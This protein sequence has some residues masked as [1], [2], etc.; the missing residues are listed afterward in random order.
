MNYRV[1]SL[2]SAFLMQ[3]LV[4][5]AQES[6]LGDCNAS[7]DVTLGEVMVCANIFLERQ[8]LANC[9][10]ADANG[11]GRVRISEVVGSAR[12][13][14]FGCPT[15]PP[16]ATPTPTATAT[17]TPT[18]TATP[19]PATATPTV[20]PTAT[21]TPTQ[22]L[23]CGNGLLEEAETCTSCPSDCEIAECTPSA[24]T[25]TFAAYL[26]AGRDV[27]AV[28]LDLNY[29]SDQ[30]QI[31]GSANNATVRARIT[32]LPTGGQSIINDRDYGVRIV[33]S[34]T[35]PLPQGELFQV[36]FDV[37]AGAATPT[38]DDLACVISS[39]S[40]EFSLPV[41]SCSCTIL[42]P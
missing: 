27:T 11:D 12:S 1:I 19:V 34:R 36:E 10:A 39:C 32:G 13:Y 35:D 40:D 16:T 21:A 3:A 31:P 17:D 25:V 9:S 37:C 14:L 26:A 5:G 18:P 7:N 42:V 8:P 22:D 28:S 29:R 2:M 30:V 41:P 15:L 4:A 23:A 6:C 20:P 24:S 38:V 33:K